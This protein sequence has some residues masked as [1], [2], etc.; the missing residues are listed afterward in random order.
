MND[1]LYQTLLES[2]KAIP[3]QIDWPTLTFSYIGPQIET[4]LGWPQNSWKSIDDW[5][6]RMHPDDRERVVNFCVSQSKS[7]IDHEA[8]YRALTQNGDYIWIRDVVHVVRKDDGEVESLV[9]FMF[10]ITERKQNEE[11]LKELNRE[12]ERMSFLDGLTH[13]PNR[14]R[15]D[16]KLDDAWAEAGRTKTPV[17]MILLDIDAFKAYND[18]YGH[19]KGDECLIQVAKALSDV[20]ESPGLLARYGGEEFALLLPGTDA[21]QAK[22]LA[23]RC[24]DAIHTLAIPHVASQTAPVVTV[25]QGVATVTPDA[26]LASYSLIEA[27]DQ[28]L[29]AAKKGGRNRIESAPAD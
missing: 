18:H 19:Y 26:T 5:V 29:Y 4:L 25:S 2:T 16:R 11:A 22:T 14:R 7:G 3:W 13:V 10:D 17:S 12:L 9:G 1:D 20:V 28:F 23:E 21:V 15:F 8:D 6:E 27:A 24:A